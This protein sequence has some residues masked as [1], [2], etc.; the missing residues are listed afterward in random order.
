MVRLTDSNDNLDDITI[1]EKLRDQYYQAIIG[2][3]K[4]V[5]VGDLLKIIELKN[6][7]SISGQAEKKFWDMINEVRQEKLPS[8]RKAKKKG[9]TAGAKKGGVKK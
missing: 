6:K 5:K 1:L 7:L 4:N 3:E 9:K 2:K 8:S